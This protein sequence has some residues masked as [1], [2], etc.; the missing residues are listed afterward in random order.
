[1]D[2]Q[3]KT[4]DFLS[5]CH[6]LTAEIYH[7]W[8]RKRASR[9]L[10]ARVD[11]DPAEIRRHLPGIMI[12]QVVADERRYVYRLVGTREATARGEDPTGKTVAEHFFGS[13]RERAL[14]N[15][16]YVVS[17]RSYMFDNEDF[18]APN[19]KLCR[20]EVLFLPLAND[21]ENVDQ[22]VVYT[23]HFWNPY[24][25]RLAADV[26]LGGSGGDSFASWRRRSDR[27]R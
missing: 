17:S 25:H 21:G 10:P 7:Y 18:F 3:Y 2:N 20:E 5:I 23:Y 11:I 12:V 9:H 8:E 4:L 14:G 15:Y 16:D 13:S 1:M 24:Q 22:I 6:P 26:R 27:E 19:G